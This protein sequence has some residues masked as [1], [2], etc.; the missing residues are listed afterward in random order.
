MRKKLSA[1]NQKKTKRCFGCYKLIIWSITL[2]EEMLTMPIPSDDTLIP[3]PKPITKE[4]DPLHIIKTRQRTHGRPA[5]IAGPMVRYSKL[6][7]RQLCREYD[8]DIVYSPM[9]LAREYVRNEHARTS[10]LSTNDKDAPLIVQVGVNNVADL[11]KFVEMVAPYCDGVGINCGCPIKEQIR[12]GIGCALIYNSELLCGMVRAV[13]DKYG[14]KLRIETKIRIHEKVDDTVELC[15]NLCD[16]GVDWITIHGRTRRTR[17]SQ[18]VNLD[19]IKYI[20]EKISDKN[21]PVIA[22]GD[23]FKSSDLE[24]ITKY[25]GASG[26]MA[27]RGLLSNPAL[28]AG[29]DTCPWGCIEKFWYW[30]LEFGGLPF[31][32]TQHHLYCMFESMQLR[33]PLLKEMMNLK[34]YAC[35]IGWFD[36]TFDFKRFGEVGYGEAVEIPYRHTKDCVS[37]APQKLQNENE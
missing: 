9:I 22:N 4:T 8:A 18:P 25:T 32:L 14:D 3:K 35:L 11:L 12:E 16:S 30:A 6:P 13:K 19:A 37:S 29:Y 28:F 17:S 2:L 33:K 24:R 36:K 7:F 23:C 1:K 34:N 26:V 21:V 5:T 31:Q 20:I 10:D 27:V 15:R